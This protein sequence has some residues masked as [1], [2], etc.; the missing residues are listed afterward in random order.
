M[1]PPAIT[2][3]ART[4][5]NW[6]IAARAKDAEPA[7][8]VEVLLGIRRDAS[9]H[10]RPGQQ[11]MHR[12]GEVRIVRQV[13]QRLCADR[14]QIVDASRRREQLEHLKPKSAG[15]VG[16]RHRQRPAHERLGGR[17][18]TRGPGRPAGPVQGRHRSPRL[19]GLNPQFT[20][21]LGD[22]ARARS[23]S[24]Q[25]LGRTA[26]QPGPAARVQLRQHQLTNQCVPE[27]QAP[28]QPA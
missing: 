23:R 10:R 18:R 21:P 27:R 17:D 11:Q 5:R 14:G 3:A 15:E 9:T 1:L 20:Q 13:V 19:P 25:R 12:R 28:I 16:W 24:L 8:G 22:D 2:A 6:A 7:D 26:A 4:T